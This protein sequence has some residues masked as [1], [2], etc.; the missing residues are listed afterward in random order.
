MWNTHYAPLYHVKP[1]LSLNLSFSA[2]CPSAS[3]TVGLVGWSRIEHWKLF[4]D[5]NSSVYL[6]VSRYDG[7]SK[8]M[9]KKN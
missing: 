2:A 9:Y 5:I 6:S 4:Q 3:E 8:I 1:K 7:C